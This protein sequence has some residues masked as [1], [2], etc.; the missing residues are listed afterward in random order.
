MKKLL[1]FGIPVL[2][3]LLGFQMSGKAQCVLNNVQIS[4][5][6]SCVFTTWDEPF[7]LI[8]DRV[9]DAIKVNGIVYALNDEEPGNPFRYSR[10]VSQDS[11][12]SCDTTG[13]VPFSG[14]VTYS[15][16]GSPTTCVYRNGEVFINCPEDVMVSQ[17]ENCL[18][19]IYP[20]TILSTPPDSVML[21]D[22]VYY[23]QGVDLLLNP[24]EVLYLKA[25]ETTCD[26]TNPVPLNDTLRFGPKICTYEDG[27]LPI[28]ILAFDYKLVSDQ[29]EL[30]WKINADEPT[31]R[32]YL[33]K[34]Y[35]GIR[36]SNVYDQAMNQPYTGVFTSGTY[37][38]SEVQRSKVYYRL[39]IEGIQNRHNYS[40]VLPVALTHRQVNNIFYQPQS[41]SIMIQAG[42]KFSGQMDLINAHGQSVMSKAVQ[43]SEG[44]FVEVQVEGVLPTG[45]YFVRFED[46]LIP[47][48][49]LFIH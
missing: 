48:T 40:N 4:S 15:M 41:R 14:T 22:T 18:I 21:G 20:D 13:A 8:V 2:F 17:G 25:G 1:R 19:F 28:V 42:Q 26:T 23:S 34:S 31:R 6:S 3:A 11:L 27:I 9:V 7:D 47:A 33:Q 35:D 5:D 36:W 45:I 46:G 24:K 37:V 44:G 10:Y 43:F 38:D 32:L 30:S 39:Y 49:R 16:L 12:A 29:V